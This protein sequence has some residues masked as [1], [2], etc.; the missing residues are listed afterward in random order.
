[1]TKRDAK[2]RFVRRPESRTVERRGW[3]GLAV[4]G[5]ALGFCLGHFPV[6]KCAPRVKDVHLPVI[7]CGTGKCP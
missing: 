4:T 3:L 6:A 2:G 5:V 1:M 7:I